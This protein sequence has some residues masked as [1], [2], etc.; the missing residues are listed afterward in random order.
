MQKSQ[1]LADPASI[2]ITKNVTPRQPAAAAAA[3]SKRAAAKPIVS[4]SPQG[5]QSRQETHRIR[6]ISSGISIR[7]ESGSTIVLVRN[8]DPGA[9]AEDVR[10]SQTSLPMA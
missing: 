7:G 10:V 5:S 3:P 9:N 6:G 2:I 1:L 4:S 8:L